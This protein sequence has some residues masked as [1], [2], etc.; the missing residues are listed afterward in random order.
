MSFLAANILGKINNLKA[1]AIS[2]VRTK[3]WFIFFFFKLS[4]FVS[5]SPAFQGWR[6]PVWW[7]LWYWY[8]D[9]YVDLLFRWPRNI[10]QQCATCVVAGCCPQWPGSR[11]DGDNKCLKEPSPV[12]CFVWLGD[13]FLISHFLMQ[14]SQIVDQVG[15][16]SVWRSHLLS[17]LQPSLQASSILHLTHCHNIVSNHNLFKSF[18]CRRAMVNLKLSFEFFISPAGSCGILLQSRAR[19]SWRTSFLSWI[20]SICDAIFQRI[21]RLIALLRRVPTSQDPPCFSWRGKEQILSR[22][23]NSRPLG[24]KGSRRDRSQLASLKRDFLSSVP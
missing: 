16:T 5:I 17:F 15:A 2:W 7:S 3:K 21:Y 23:A 20:Y 18:I 19:C 24:Q 22:S 9:F 12:I 4:G 13:F 10:V 11:P 8:L 14:R 6:S 1:R